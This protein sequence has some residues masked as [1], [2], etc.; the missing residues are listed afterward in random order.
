MGGWRTLKEVLRKR[1][2]P[3]AGFQVS[4]KGFSSSATVASYRK[5]KIEQILQEAAK[6]GLFRITLDRDFWSDD[7]FPAS[8]VRTAC[9]R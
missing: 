3:A 4:A 5:E 7:R 6:R 9:F 2:L 1:P 8:V